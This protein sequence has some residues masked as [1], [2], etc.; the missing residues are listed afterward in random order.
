MPDDVAQEKVNALQ[1]LGADV[2]RVRPASIVDKKQVRA[3]IVAA[4]YIYNTMVVVLAVCGKQFVCRVKSR[5]EHMLEK[6][7]ARR[8]AIDFGRSDVVKSLEDVHISHE[9]QTGSASVVVTTTSSH[10][11]AEGTVDDPMDQ[12][13]LTKPR[14]FFADQFEVHNLISYG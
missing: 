3:D 14:G 5:N 12:D 6:N 1:A 13:L 11:H 10:V 8:A 4:N 2:Q 7:I 9:L